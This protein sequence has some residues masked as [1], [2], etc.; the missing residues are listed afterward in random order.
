[1]ETNSR[2]MNKDDY[3]DEN[4]TPGKRTQSKEKM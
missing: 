4:Q 3:E 1:M 2:V